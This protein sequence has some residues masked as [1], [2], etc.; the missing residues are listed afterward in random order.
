LTQV[1]ASFLK[2]VLHEQLEYADVGDELVPHRAILSTKA[3]VEMRALG[4]TLGI[5]AEQDSWTEEHFDSFFRRRF[6][7]GCYLWVTSI[8]EVG[9]FEPLYWAPYS[10]ERRDWLYV[11][12]KFEN[13]G[14]PC[15]VTSTDGNLSV[16]AELD[17]KF[18]MVFGTK[19]EVSMFDVH[20]GGREV[21]RENFVQYL[22]ERA[23]DFGKGNVY[24]YLASH[25][26][27]MLT[28]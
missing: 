9:E 1:E 15:G 28:A 20:F 10:C 23:V 24:G 17:S 13:G 4:G 14:Y 21:L 8:D 11:Y 27:P 19:K 25:I 22:D 7:Q 3:G 18:T 16:F 26:L 12:A 2:S 5:G 6:S